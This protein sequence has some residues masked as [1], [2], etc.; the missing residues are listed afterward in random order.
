M[1]VKASTFKLRILE[2]PN[3]NLTDE[4]FSTIPDFKSLRLLAA[5]Q[6][7]VLSHVAPHSFDLLRPEYPGTWGYSG[8][9]TISDRIEVTGDLW[10]VS[11]EDP[12]FESAAGVLLLGA[13]CLVACE[14][15]RLKRKRALLFEHR[16]MLLRPKSTGH[17]VVYDVPRRDFI[18]VTYRKRDKGPGSVMVFWDA[19]PDGP[20]EVVGVEMCF[21]S[22]Y[23]HRIWAGF[24]AL[25]VEPK[26]PEI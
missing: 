6:S 26:T 23:E 3:R 13:D 17:E 25:T 15:G 1:Q 11:F 5:T 21:D 4:I 8:A 10:N 22:F 12:E 9:L 18:L 16:L 20:H 14:Q 2:A 7:H 24:L 19:E